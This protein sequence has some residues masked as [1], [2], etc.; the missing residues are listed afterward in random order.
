MK[1]Y[2]LDFN[3]CTGA[4]YQQAGCQVVAPSKISFMKTFITE[5]QHISAYGKDRVKT[6]R[7]LRR[8]RWD[9]CKTS[10]KEQQFTQGIPCKYF[11]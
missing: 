1:I 4:S 3:F 11:F 7:Q 8:E 9:F 10:I 5:T 6:T 2:T